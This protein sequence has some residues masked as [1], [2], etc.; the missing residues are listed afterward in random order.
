MYSKLLMDFCEKFGNLIL[1]GFNFM[2]FAMRKLT[3]SL[4]FPLEALLSL[5]EI[6]VSCLKIGHLLPKSHLKIRS[7]QF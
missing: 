7:F 4:E 5:G 1:M 6:E 2:T 3:A